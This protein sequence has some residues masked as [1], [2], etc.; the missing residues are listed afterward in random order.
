MCYDKPSQIEII[1][2]D[3]DTNSAMVYLRTGRTYVHQKMIE[4][5][6]AVEGNVV[7]SKIDNYF[8]LICPN[9]HPVKYAAKP[10]QKRRSKLK[11]ARSTSEEVAGANCKNGSTN[12][13]MRTSSHL[14]RFI[15]KRQ[16]SPKRLDYS[17]LRDKIKTAT[18]DSSSSAE[19]ND[20]NNRPQLQVF[21]PINPNDRKVSVDKEP[22]L[23]GIFK[24]SEAVVDWDKFNDKERSKQINL[25]PK[26]RFSITT[27]TKST[28]KSTTP[29]LRRLNSNSLEACV[30]KCNS[31]YDKSKQNLCWTMQNNG[32]HY[33]RSNDAST[34]LELL[35]PWKHLP[36]KVK[37]V[38]SKDYLEEIQNKLSSTTSEDASSISEDA[39]E[40]PEPANKA[41]IE[42]ISSH[43]F[44]TEEIKQNEKEPLSVLP[45]AS[46]SQVSRSTHLE[47]M[48]YKLQSTADSLFY[49]RSNSVDSDDVDCTSSQAESVSIQ[50]PKMDEQPDDHNNDKIV[51]FNDL[52]M[53]DEYERWDWGVSNVFS[54]FQEIKSQNPQVIISEVMENETATVSSNLDTSESESND[55]PL[56]SV[57]SNL[58]SDIDTKRSH[59]NLLSAVA[60]NAKQFTDET[61][62]ITP[63][64]DNKPKGKF[65][66]LFE[67]RQKLKL[68]SQV[69]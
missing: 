41:L 42:E 5:Q 60:V 14:R 51:A 66:L 33:E 10:I 55:S 39:V 30:Q 29:S 34:P 46:S 3:K 43:L 22:T 32:F 4:K 17:C 62:K 44:T 53:N 47:D 9:A 25:I 24:P 69:D 38:A 26:E 40:L 59:S 67:K 1:S 21:T 54:F 31:L 28:N 49:G 15:N 18:T 20:Q 58:D 23:H 16:L 7:S 50:Q 37:L 48:L 68:E 65:Q 11:N 63:N 19:P 57:S 64:S 52:D 27:T 2:V 61:P 6:L 56:A 45:D 36:E 12:E 13:H 8:L 35:Q